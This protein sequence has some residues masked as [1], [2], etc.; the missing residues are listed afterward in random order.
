MGWLNDKTRAGIIAVA[1]SLFPLLVTL[2]IVDLSDA[3]IG[4]IMLFV[5]N[6]ITLAALVFNQGQGPV[7]VVDD[8]TGP[9]E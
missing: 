7:V 8:T 1:Q 3:Q 6:T 2:Q 9:V 4:A 5:T